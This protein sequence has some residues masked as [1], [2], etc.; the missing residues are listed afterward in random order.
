M[1][2]GQ[3]VYSR[4]VVVLIATMATAGCFTPNL[5]DWGGPEVGSAFGSAIT[6]GDVDGDGRS[7]LIIGV[8][9]VFGG[10]V[11]VFS[12]APGGAGLYNVPGLDLE[13]VELGAS[14]ATLGDV[15]GDDLTDFVS[16]ATNTTHPG[17]AFVLRGVDGALIQEVAGDQIDD[18]FGFASA[19]LGDADGDDSPDFA[20]GAPR[21]DG[22]AGADSGRVSAF[23]ADSGLPLY[24][25]DGEA[26]G[27]RFGFALARV[28]DA[29]G[30][31]VDD[32]AVGAPF[33]DGPAGADAGRAYLLSGATG[34]VLWAIDGPA[35]GAEFG[36]SVGGVRDA[37]GDGAGDWIVGAKGSATAFSGAAGAVLDSWGGGPLFG[38]SVAGSGDVNGDGRGDWIVA[39]D[40]FSAAVYDGPTGV[41]L[42][43]L[44]PTAGFPGRP[45]GG[46]VR[47]AGVGRVN[48]DA[49]DDVAVGA[50]FYV[51][52]VNPDGGAVGAVWVYS[53]PPSPF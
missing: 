39:V 53:I 41:A 13:V 12:G 47:V 33:H 37:D 49:K 36:R 8:P 7:D 19:A 21:R 50:P 35:A 16:G 9:G 30:D 40:D 5:H 24:D 52:S 23:A 38:Q 22:P 18:H 17:Q 48:A 43:Q 10:G 25:A 29:D 14:V 51:I 26:A 31:G 44:F 2:R 28:P 15:D 20:V 45:L 32:L 27:D 11:Q 6:G 46:T 34:A 42:A 4:A 1:D 3:R